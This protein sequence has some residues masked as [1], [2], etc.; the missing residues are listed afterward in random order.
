MTVLSHYSYG[1]AGTASDSYR[2]PQ[3]RRPVCHAHSRWMASCP[4]CSEA[5]KPDKETAK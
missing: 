2:V 3:P 5:H 4:D 1:S